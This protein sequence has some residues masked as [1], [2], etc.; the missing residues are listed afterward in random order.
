MRTS[1]IAYMN[2]NGGF[3]RAAHA[4]GAFRSPAGL[5]SPGSWLFNAHVPC[6]DQ[7]TGTA[8]RRLGEASP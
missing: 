5:V 3:A 6:T 2:G 4:M 1:T 8:A 7:K